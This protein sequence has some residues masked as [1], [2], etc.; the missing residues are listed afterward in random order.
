MVTRNACHEVP[1]H[2][3]NVL[4]HQ[5][6]PPQLFRS[7]RG[8][9]GSSSEIGIMLYII[10]C[11]RSEGRSP[12]GILDHWVRWDGGLDPAGNSSGAVAVAVVT[13]ERVI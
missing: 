1:P 11:D 2:S 9:E 3:T 13:T 6:L 5:A 10:V 7:A 8:Y 12:N 4:N